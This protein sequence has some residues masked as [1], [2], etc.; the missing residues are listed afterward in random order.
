VRFHILLPG[1][2]AAKE[3]S[4]REKRPVTDKGMAFAET[5]PETLDIA[6]WAWYIYLR[7]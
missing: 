6:S 2:W 5:S 1:E 4:G 3:E 7:R